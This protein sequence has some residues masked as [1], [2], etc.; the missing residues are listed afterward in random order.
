MMTDEQ[1]YMFDLLGY[2]VIPNAIDEPT[3][4]RMRAD[5]DAQGVKDVQNSSSLSRFVDFF[6]WGPDWRNLIDHPAVYPYLQDLIEPKFRLDHAYGMAM[7]ADGTQAPPGGEMHHEADIYQHGCFYVANSRGMHNGLIVVSFAL[8]DI[9][10]GAG[11]FIC[12]PGSHKCNYPTPR[13]FYDMKDNPL[14]RQ[15]PQKAGDALIFTEALTHGTMPWTLKNAERRS[16]LLKYCP[17]YMQ[18]A[19]KHMDSN[20]EGLTDRQKKILAGPY[21]N[22]RPK[23]DP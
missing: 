8:N 4:N 20:I 6:K 7:R 18:W 9:P 23:L 1:K 2:A 13:R 22:A 10:V 14:W 3:L 19:A 5:M 17:L 15:V 21:V 16:A 11:G 12:I